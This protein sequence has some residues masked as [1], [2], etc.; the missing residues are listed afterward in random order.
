M[1][2]PKCNEP[3]EQVRVVSECWQ[4]AIVDEGGKVTDYGLIEEVLETV[5]VEHLDDDCF[6]DLTELLSDI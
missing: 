2:C 1:N 3:I 6:A 5:K 4:K